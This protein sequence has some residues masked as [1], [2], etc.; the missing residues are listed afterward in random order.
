MSPIV[1]AIIELIGLSTAVLYKSSSPSKPKR[2][3]PL[4]GSNTLS[5]RVFL[6]FSKTR[7]DNVRNTSASGFTC[8]IVNEVITSGEKLGYNCA[9]VEALTASSLVTLA[10]ALFHCVFLPCNS[11]YKS[12]SVLGLSL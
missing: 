4:R 5:T 6:L 3:A 12:C 2:T 8:N 7:S 9:I 11:L 10:L 1:A